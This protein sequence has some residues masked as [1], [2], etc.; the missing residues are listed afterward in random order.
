MAERFARIGFDGEA[1]RVVRVERA[2]GEQGSLATA[3]VR[4]A[5]DEKN[6][7]SATS[8][9]VGDWVAVERVD[10]ATALVRAV[11]ERTSALTRTDPG[12]AAEQVLAANVDVV[13]VVA[14]CDRLRIPRIE[15]EL[16]VAWASGARPVV[17]L[18]KT[19]LAADAPALERRLRQR[20]RADVVATSVR[21]E[22]GL[23]AVTEIMRPNLTA[24]LFGPSGAGKSS[25][26]NALVGTDVLATGSVRA[27][28]QR[29]RHTTSSRQLVPVPGG[30]VLI[31]IPGIRSLSLPGAGENLGVAFADILELAAGCR[32]RDCRHDREPDCA[33]TSAVDRG[34]LDRERLASYR[35]L[36]A[37]AQDARARRSPR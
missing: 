3:V 10:D 14:P 29:G 22:G 35:K 16:L 33:V 11:L 18:S 8:V 32:F 23:T 15:R 25:L 27:R 19:D 30:G 34:R 17:V 1:G 28:D 21:D 26:V 24:V 36:A 12:G 13:L 20:L 2:P 9:A 6:A 5:A 37:E 31:D 4:L 7:L